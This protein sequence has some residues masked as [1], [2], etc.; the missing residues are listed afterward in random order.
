VAADKKWARRASRP[1]HFVRRIAKVNGR[2][3]VDPLRLYG[4]PAMPTTS[5]FVAAMRLARGLGAR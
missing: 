2:L 3:A 4:Y 1:R 5:L